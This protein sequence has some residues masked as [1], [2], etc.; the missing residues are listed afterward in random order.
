MAKKKPDLP[1]VKANAALK[2]AY[3]AAYI[4][5]G[6]VQYRAMEAVG[7]KSRSTIWEWR[8]TDSAFA[9]A[10]IEARE[11]EGDWYENQLRTLSAGIPE[12]DKDNKLT[13]WKERPDTTAINSVLNAKFKDRGYGYRIKHEHEHTQKESRIN[14]ERLSKNE[15]E[16]WY[17]LLEKATIPE[18]EITE[19]QIIE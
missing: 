14:L 1:A 7:I 15:R 9:N 5:T 4:A 16:A 3:I 12:L 17:W 2:E 8:N 13:G 19:A 10:L 18:E 11:Q 6:F